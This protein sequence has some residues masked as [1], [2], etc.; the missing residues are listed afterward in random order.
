DGKEED[1]KSLN[2]QGAQAVKAKDLDKG[3]ALFEKALEVDPSNART[4]NN[5]GYAWF[6]KGDTDKALKYLEWAVRFDPGN[7][8]AKKNLEYVRKKISGKSEQAAAVAPAES[9]DQADENTPADEDT[10]RDNGDR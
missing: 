5:L 9:S 4:C 3:I 1:V 2:K 7:A 6:L 10:V 8:K